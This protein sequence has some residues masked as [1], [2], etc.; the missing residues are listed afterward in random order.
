[1]LAS[2]LVLWLHAADTATRFQNVLLMVSYWIPAFVAV[3]IVDWLIRIRGRTAINPATESTDRLDAV[4][5]M[6]AFVVAYAAAIPFMNT[7][8]IEGPIAKAWH[9]ADAAYFVNLLV[10]AVLYGCYRQLRVSR[11]GIHH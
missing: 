5:A 10:A 6:I 9:G 4:A 3:V 2:A 7:S 11:S 8:L 1:V